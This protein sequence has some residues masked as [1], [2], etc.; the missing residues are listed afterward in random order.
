MH[1]TPQLQTMSVTSASETIAVQPPTGSRYIGF[2]ANRFD[3][4]TCGAAS[5]ARAHVANPHARQQGDVD[6]RCSYTAAA[7]AVAV[8]AA[9]AYSLNYL[10]PYLARCSR[11]A[12]ARTPPQP[13]VEVPGWRSAAPVAGRQAVGP[14]H[15]A[16]RLPLPCPPSPRQLRPR[17][18]PQSPRPA[19]A[20]PQRGARSWL[21]PPP[22]SIAPCTL[23]DGRA[24]LLCHQPPRP[25]PCSAAGCRCPT[26]ASPHALAGAGGLLTKSMPFCICALS[27]G[28]MALKAA[29][30]KA[31][32]SPRPM[33]LATPPGPRSTL[34]AK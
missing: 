9:P 12:G 8:T 7:A 30:S 2:G 29:C 31:S 26:S 10:T 6:V 3:T 19:R 27:S 25:H 34:V 1:H 28:T 15:R 18:P 5:T 22:P 20:Q 21:P 16:G 14:A 11:Q 4:T 32:I 24:A 17:R 23:Q 33:T 13:A